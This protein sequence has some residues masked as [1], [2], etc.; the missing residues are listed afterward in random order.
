MQIHGCPRHAAIRMSPLSRETHRHAPAAAGARVPYIGVIGSGR[1]YCNST[2]VYYCLQ[3]TVEA[4][5]SSQ[6]GICCSPAASLVQQAGVT[7][8]ATASCVNH[9]QHAS[10]VG[11]AAC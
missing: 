2:A 1:C 6:Q 3:T 4:E 11:T 7:A 5:H 9:S 10:A 8:S